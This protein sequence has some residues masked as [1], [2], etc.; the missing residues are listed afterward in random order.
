MWLGW[1]GC[2]NVS[3][4]PASSAE[5]LSWPR[6]R[7]K[8]WPASAPVP[9]TVCCTA[10]SRTTDAVPV[11]TRPHLRATNDAG[12]SARIRLAAARV[13]ATALPHRAGHDRQRACRHTR[14]RRAMTSDFLIYCRLSSGA[15]KLAVPRE[16]RPGERRMSS[17]SCARTRTVQT[18]L[19]YKP[20]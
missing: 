14:S 1:P 2:S 16:T 7:R 9:P 13:T 4:G 20:A 10:T 18:G 12:C 11:E 8:C 6:L 3:A 17:G 5:R 19:G 15:M